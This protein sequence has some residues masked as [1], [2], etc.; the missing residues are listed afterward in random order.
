MKTY[1]E[2]GFADDKNLPVIG[3]NV[4]AEIRKAATQEGLVLMIHANGFDAQKFAVEGDVDVIAHGMWHWGELNK[5][6]EL[7]NEIK[8][9]L[10]QIV[11]KRIGYQPTI[12][13]LYVSWRILIPTT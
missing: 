2:R 4:L 3:P 5:K 1:F 12:Q 10:D 6:T 13:V 8:R 11:D 9:L 7:P